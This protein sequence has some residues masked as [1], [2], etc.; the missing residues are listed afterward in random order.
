[1]T[2]RD[3][4]IESCHSVAEMSVKKEDVDVSMDSVKQEDVSGDG[5]DGSAKYE[6]VLGPWGTPASTY[7]LAR[8]TNTMPL[9]TEGTTMHREEE[10]GEA[11]RLLPQRSANRGS[12]FNKR[13]NAP[14][15][16]VD[17]E[18]TTFVGHAERGMSSAYAF[19]VKVEER[20]HLV[21]ATEWYKFNMKSARARE[22]TLEEAEAMMET[23]EK[24]KTRR[25]AMPADL[26]EDLVKAPTAKDKAKGR[27]R[28]IKVNMNTI[29]RSETQAGR[30]EAAERMDAAEASSLERELV[31]ALANAS[32]DDGVGDLREAVKSKKQR[33]RA[34]KALE[35][36]EG[37]DFD[38]DQEFSDNDD[39]NADDD[40]PTIEGRVDD[41]LS[42]SSD[43]DRVD[44]DGFV[45]SVLKAAG[46]DLEADQDD[47]G[48]SDGESDVSMEESNAF[49]DGSDAEKLIIDEDDEG[50]S[51]KTSRK[52]AGGMGLKRKKR[53]QKRKGEAAD[54]GPATTSTTTAAPSAAGNAAKRAR[55]QSASPQPV[56]LEGMLVQALTEERLTLRDLVKRFSLRRMTEEKRND[57]MA[58]LKRLAKKD[59]EY[60]KLRPKK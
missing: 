40:E 37:G 26:N 4:S 35:E 50:A 39:R 49:T 11:D 52:S 32:D 45:P 34:R 41:I 10:V 5:G 51:T 23:F 7:H 12:F 25:M 19:L 28:A 36:E 38:V 60:L 59:G 43:E 22:F 55:L 20:F 56:T 29:D 44:A 21:S 16:L 53:G 13:G 1:M 42:D 58:M 24:E 9:L 57:F 54:A 2:W 30:M 33:E 27:R 8:F 47:A 14:W 48:E 3:E 31:E 18:E 6:V 46:Q 15:M 17:G